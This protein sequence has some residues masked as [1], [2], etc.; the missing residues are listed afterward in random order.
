VRPKTSPLGR[1][2][3][4]SAALEQHLGGQRKSA[5]GPGADRLHIEHCSVGLDERLEPCR[6]HAREGTTAAPLAGVAVAMYSFP[7]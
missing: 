3:S 7:P 6:F 2:S 4:I 1:S 5:R